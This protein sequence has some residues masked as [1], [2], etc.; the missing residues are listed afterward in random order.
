[1]SDMLS[2][3]VSGL[4]AFQKALATVSHNIANANTPGYSRQ[5]VHLATN[6]AE[7]TGGGWIGNGVSSTTV[8]R[9]YNGFLV[10]QTLSASSS[11]NQFDTVSNLASSLNNLFGDSSTGLSAT[12]Q[13]FSQ[14][15]QTMANAPS[16]TTA[17][18]AVLNQAQT[19][20]SQFKSYESSLHSLD[21]QIGTQLGTEAST[22][23]SLAKNI[24]SLNQQISAAQAS[25]QQP[26]NDLMD[27]RDQLISQLAGHINVNTVTQSDGSINVYIG[28]GQSLVVGTS[29]MTLAAGSDTFN[30]GQM[31]LSVLTSNGAVDVT[32]SLSG[33]TVGGLL[34]FQEQMLQ[35]AHNVLGQAA[36]TLA[37]L[38]NTQNAAGLDQSGAIGG[39]LLAV[40]GV[41]V[42]TSDTNQG[43]ANVAGVIGDFTTLNANDGILRYDG[44]QWSLADATSGKS[45]ALTAST[46]GG[47]TTLTGGG[48][49]LTVTGA[50]Q[51]GDRFLVQ[52]LSQAV[53]GLTLLTTDPAKLAAAA[54]VA[55]GA[56]ATNTGTGAIDGGTV[57]T[58][59]TWVRGNYTVQFTS[60]STYTIKDASGAT[61]VAN[62]SYTDGATINFRGIQV[63]ISGA[64]ATG[65]SF[66]VNDN[67]NGTGDNRNALKLA[68]LLNQK[69]FAG[70]TQSV[71]D[72]VNA[73]VGTVG[74][75]T[76]QAQNGATA[77]QNLLTSAQTAQQGVSG[78]NLDEEAA[79]MLKLQQAYQAAAQV[80]KISDSL[81][82]SLINAF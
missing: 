4:L 53:S 23:T 51:A 9:A 69:V 31:R 36:A 55:T 27:Q 58:T 46:S 42:L 35:P 7:P 16:Q 49:V 18:Q 66:A 19:L 13:G 77:Q 71:A 17:R 72:L 47:T 41:R 1:M 2:T 70:G 33:G 44:T 62:G 64:P 37:N 12:L 6:P 78:V 59:T 15:V 38:V 73:Y 75:Q 20:I 68:G 28:N 48:L 50:A 26:P 43:S 24:A 56:G 25:M 82:Q 65:D 67:A 40:G 29:A 74:L 54:P 61:V 32:Q 63:V 76:S 34:Q 14:A 11:Y 79:N 81:F 60:P 30:S 80:I 57:P 8:T 10:G 5:S 22:I 45:Q 52:P 21:N 39:P 3:G